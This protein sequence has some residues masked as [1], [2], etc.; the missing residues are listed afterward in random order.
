MTYEMMVCPHD[1]AS[2]PDRWFLFMQ[3]LAQNLDTHLKFDIALDFADFHDNLGKADIVYANPSD[4]LRLIGEGMEAI[5]RPSNVHDEVVFV[6]QEGIAQ[7]TLESLHGQQIASVEALQ[8]TKLAMHILAGKG[9]KPAGITNFESWTSIPGAIW[10]GE[11]SYGFIY[12][13]TY[14]GLSDQGK[15]MVQVFHTSDERVNFHTLLVG[16]QA[17]E[18]K[19]AITQLLTAMHT[20][21]HGKDVLH[22]LGIEQWLPVT[23]DDIAQ[24]KKIVESY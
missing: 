13:D 12:K 20:D 5:V 6:A 4:T 18:K 7:P 2:N 22:E 15:G 8:P 10:R 3:Y 17:M 23:P 9:I 19:D 21:A 11:V 16:R 24:I 1:T 14:D